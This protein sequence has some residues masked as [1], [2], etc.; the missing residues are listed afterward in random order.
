MTVSLEMVLCAITQ[1]AG[2]IVSP[3]RHRGAGDQITRQFMSSYYLNSS[4]NDTGY[5]IKKGAYI[6]N[7]KDTIFMFFLLTGMQHEINKCNKKGN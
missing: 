4:M 2:V 1:K 3:A 5:V 7:Q 6:V